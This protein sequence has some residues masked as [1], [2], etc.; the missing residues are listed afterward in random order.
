MQKSGKSTKRLDRLAPNLIHVCGFIWEWTQAKNNQPLDTPG[1]HL[2]GGVQGSNIQKYGKSTKLLDRLAPNLVHVCGFIWEQTQ[3]KNNQP[4]DTPGGGILGGFQ[5]SK[6][7]KYGKSTKLLDRL[8][9][10]FVHVCRFIWEWSQAEF[11]AE[12]KQSLETRGSFWGLDGQNVIKG[13]RNAMIC[14]EKINYIKMKCT[15]RHT[16][17]ATIPGEAG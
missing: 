9:P 1:G 5:G 12:N 6:I 11:P 2:G 4:L 16:Y 7:Q 15:N 13:L 17:A 14:R 8:A 10:N 3:A